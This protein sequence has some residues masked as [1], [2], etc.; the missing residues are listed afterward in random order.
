MAVL[1]EA[2]EDLSTST[3]PETMTSTVIVVFEFASL[4]RSRPLGSIDTWNWN[5]QE[6]VCLVV[7]LFTT[8]E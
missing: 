6:T 1:L 8:V 3:I 5:P 2:G 4:T 7:H